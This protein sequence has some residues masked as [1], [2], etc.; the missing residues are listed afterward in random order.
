MPMDDLSQT[1][2]GSD[3]AAAPREGEAGKEAALSDVSSVANNASSGGKDGENT[4]E[5]GGKSV[6][7]RSSEDNGEGEGQGSTEVPEAYEVTLPE[8]AELDQAALERFSP[9][10]K[11]LNLSN[12]QVQK[13]ADLRLE[14]QQ[15]QAQ[16]W[17]DT[18]QSWVKQGE[19]DVE[20]GGDKYRHSV[21]T[22]QSAIGQFADAEVVQFLEDSGLGDHPAM[23]RM[24][25]RIGAAM[26]DD[27]LVTARGGMGDERPSAKLNRLYPTMNP[28]T[29]KG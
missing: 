23:L 8:G 7:T 24:F 19:K 13:L 3:Q 16:Q 27:S 11:E 21:A 5:Q 22:A 14:E 9:A 28:S 2:T 4:N 17:A 12:E 20:I 29:N 18:R 25:H 15:A 1:E 6:L 26:T 10:F